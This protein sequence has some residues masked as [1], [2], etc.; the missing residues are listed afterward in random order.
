ME[1]DLIN[2]AAVGGTMAT[3]LSIL[4]LVL[5]ADIVVKAVIILLVAASVWCW[6]II[7]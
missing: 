5:R 2:A 6:A 1:Q 7:F 4:S 3:D